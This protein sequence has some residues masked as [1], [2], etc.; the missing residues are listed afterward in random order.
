MTDY[1]FIVNPSAGKADRTEAITSAVKNLKVEG[2]V[3]VYT[4]KSSD[5]CIR[6]VVDRLQSIQN[7]VRLYACGG[8]GTFCAVLNGVYQS[9][10][11]GVEIGC[12]PT[13]S[14]NDFLRSF[15]IEASRFRSIKD[16][17]EGTA[18]PFDII[19]VTS[20]SGKV[21][22]CCNIVSAGFDADVCRNIEDIRRMP[23]VSGVN[24]Y[25][26]SVVKTLLSHLGHS[27]TVIADGKEI[28][29]EQKKEYLFAL[30]ANGKFYG[31]GYKPSP[32]SEMD[33]GK[34]DMVLIEKLSRLQF[35][36][37]L[38]KYRTGDYL[39]VEKMKEKIVY[40]PVH[41]MQILCDKPIDINLDGEVIAFKD[42]II[43]IIPRG[44]NFILPA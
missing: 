8:D 14:G 2:N 25:R 40:T 4:S 37:L 23:L 43:E 31:G 12:I 3:E 30:A 33:D 19:R 21:L 24:A 5:D 10:R 42:P 44:M 39:A 36:G 11:T 18:K 1:I 41:N 22:V 26:L 6:F 35:L 16:M 7:D 29:N 20:A 32:E 9:G 17:A 28:A 13:G 27:F 15:P 38:G 34:L